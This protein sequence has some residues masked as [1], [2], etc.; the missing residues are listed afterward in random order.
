[1]DKQH[2]ILFTPMKI[3]NV[4]IRNRFVEA[5]MEGTCIIEWTQETKYNA[6]ARD[7]YIERAKNGMGLFI[8]G[9]A[10]LRSMIGGKWLHK[11]PKVFQEAAPLLSEIHSYGA[12]VF[13]Q[14]GSGWG[15]S[16]TL[17]TQMTPLLDKKLV[18]FLARGIPAHL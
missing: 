14:I 9:L 6:K 18:G 4:E 8:P 15:R 10:P 7:Y 16:F 13:M 3:G 5:P 17:N 2:E 12:K 1:M 11:H